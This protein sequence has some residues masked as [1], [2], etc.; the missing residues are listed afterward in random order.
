MTQPNGFGHYALIVFSPNAFYRK[1]N[2][3]GLAGPLGVRK[4]PEFRSSQ[5]LTPDGAVQIIC[6][7]D[8]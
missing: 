6:P 7:P 2:S 4:G 1:K 8:T 5:V 3:R